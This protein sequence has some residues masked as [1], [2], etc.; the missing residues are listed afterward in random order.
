[1][2]VL[3]D[4]HNLRKFLTDTGNSPKLYFYYFIWSNGKKPSQATGPLKDHFTWYSIPLT[5]TVAWNVFLTI[6]LYT[7][8][9]IRISIFF[10]FSSNYASFCEYGES[11]KICQLLMRTLYSQYFN[12]VIWHLISEPLEKKMQLTFLAYLTEKFHCAFSPY[13]LNEL[14]HA[15]TQ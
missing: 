4:L 10:C 7:R 13:A 12:H 14:N 3:S 8:Y 9:R 6:S 1:M 15:L 2:Q 5:G 11:A